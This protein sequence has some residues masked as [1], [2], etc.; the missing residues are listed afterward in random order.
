MHNQALTR[1]IWSARRAGVALQSAKE[2]RLRPLGLVTAHYSLLAA[3]EAN[4]GITGAELARELG[5]SP[6]NIAGLAARLVGS[7]LI[8]RHPHER[9]RQVLETWLTPEGSRLLALA[10]AE[11]EDLEKSIVAILGRSGAEELRTLLDKLSAGLES[12]FR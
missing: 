9:H 7:G 6:Q 11:V 4:P 5:V 1:V 10:E 8:E 3:V 12:D 2:L